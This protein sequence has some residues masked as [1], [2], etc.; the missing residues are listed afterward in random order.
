MPVRLDLLRHGEAQPAAAQGDPARELTPHGA[1]GMRALGMRLRGRG[2]QPQRVLVSTYFRTWQ[3]AALVLE[4]LAVEPEI[5]D[6][7]VPERGPAEAAIALAARL[8]GT[9]HAMLVGH[10]P[11]LGQLLEWWTGASG[12]FSAGEFVAVEFAATLDRHSGRVIERI[13]PG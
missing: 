1:A 10:Q 13:S 2:W 9:S 12:P 5:V 7:L 4:G 3:T 6:E 11:L 8:E